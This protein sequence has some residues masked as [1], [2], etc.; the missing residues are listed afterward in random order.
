MTQPADPA[1]FPACPFQGANPFSSDEQG[2]LVAMAG[3]AAVGN[4]TRSEHTKQGNIKPL[5]VFT[6]K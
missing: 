4:W 3:E 1:F 5:E 6:K 2:K